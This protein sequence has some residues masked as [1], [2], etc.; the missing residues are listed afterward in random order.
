MQHAD[1]PRTAFQVF[2]VLAEGADRR[3][4]TFEQQGIEEALM[5]PGQIPEF[6]RYGKGHQEIVG[7]D[8]A[9]ELAFQPLLAFV[10]LAVR[11]V[12]V[13]AGVRHQA[14]F[15]TGGT[16]RQHLRRQGRAAGFHG[17]QGLALAG[18][19]HV[20]ILLQVGRLVAADDVGEGNHLTTPQAIEKRSIRALMR[21][22]A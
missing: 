19:H 17:G 3:P 14:S 6:G 10:M 22:L 12:A 13:P 2:V 1:R 18:Q 9:L 5:A 8:L 4:G 16:T 15:V 21:T 11:A 7:R 20:A